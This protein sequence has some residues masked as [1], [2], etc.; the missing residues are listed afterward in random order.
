MIS[1]SREHLQEVNQTYREHGWFAVKWGL[2]LIWTGVVS[3]IHGICPAF[4]KFRAPRNVMRVAR[5]IKERGIPG[6][7]E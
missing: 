4:F 3:I 1:K 5:L 2:F 7:L 6:E